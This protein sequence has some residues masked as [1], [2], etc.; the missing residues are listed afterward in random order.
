MLKLKKIDFNKKY[1]FRESRNGLVS[2]VTCDTRTGGAN[3]K[4]GPAFCENEE[5]FKRIKIAEY[6]QGWF[7]HENSHNIAIKRVCDAYISK[8]LPEGIEKLIIP[9]NHVILLGSQG[10]DIYHA[11]SNCPY[12]IEELRITATV[13]PEIIKQEKLFDYLKRSGIHIKDMLSYIMPGETVGG[14]I[15]EMPCCESKL[16]YDTWR[17]D[18]YRRNVGIKPDGTGPRIWVRNRIIPHE[19]KVIMTPEEAEAIFDLSKFN[20]PEFGDREFK[21]IA[22]SNHLHK[23]CNRLGS[24]PLSEAVNPVWT[25]GSYKILE[26]NIVGPDS[27]ADFWIYHEKLFD[28]KKGLEKQIRNLKQIPEGLIPCIDTKGIF[29]NTQYCCR[30]NGGSFGIYGIIKDLKDE[31]LLSKGV[32]HFIEVGAVHYRGWNDTWGEFGRGFSELGR[33][34]EN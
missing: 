23:Y 25:D 27:N 2:C 10:K 34:D 11:D 28:I 16:P 26:E 21:V 31:T 19:K 1:R 8:P 29:K 13:T 5:R 12:V 7:N 3:N 22:V 14:Q 20:S 32:S 4:E 24:R 33:F 6:Y 15:C 18:D 30:N 17:I 9:E